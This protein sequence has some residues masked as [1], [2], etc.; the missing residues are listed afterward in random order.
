M[1]FEGGVFSAAAFLMGLIDAAR[2]P[3]TPS[4]CRSRPDLHGAAGPRPGGDRPRRPAFGRR[5]PRR[6]R[7]RRL[8]RLRARASASWRRWRSLML[9]FPREL[10]TLFLDDSARQR[11]VMRSPSPSCSS[12]RCS[13]WST[14]RRW[15]A[16]G[17][18]RG[19]HD[20]RVPMIFASLGY[21]ALGIRHRRLAG[22]RRRL[23]GQG[24]WVGLAVGL[25]F[26]AVLMSG[27]GHG[28]NGS[29]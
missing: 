22:V 26:V 17:M 25:A 2:S 12:P 7:P 27:A 28:G 29:A 8:D 11:R 9:A 15:S 19:L 14:A 3:R 18:L 10:V 13:R 23:A 6:H 1:G 20:T 4:R 5:R 24:I 21:W 16:P